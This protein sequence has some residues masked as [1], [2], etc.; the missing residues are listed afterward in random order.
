MQLL[1]NK[2]YMNEIFEKQFLIRST[3]VNASQHLRTSQLLTMLQDTA[4]DHVT[5]IGMGKDKTMD[6]GLLWVIARQFV[7]IERIP[8]YDETVRLKTWAGKH[9]HFLFPRYYEISDAEGQVIVRASAVW[10]LMDI[11]T[12]AAVLPEKRGISVP[13]ITIGNEIPYHAVIGKFETDK[14]NEFSVPYSYID[15]NGHMNNARFFDLADDILPANGKRL[16]ELRMEYHN[17]VE[18]GEVLKID[19]TGTGSKYYLK[20]STDKLVFKMLLQYYE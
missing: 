19:W 15:L 14:H 6:R 13:G 10:T 8:H 3:M 7:Q 9:M 4:T 2:Q 18:Q 17:E 11:N 12:R 16:K 20:G 5:E 1:K